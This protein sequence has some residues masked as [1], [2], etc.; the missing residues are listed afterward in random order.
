[1]NDEEGGRRRYPNLSYV[2]HHL[3]PT[4]PYPLES[5]RHGLRWC[6][7][8][9]R[10][11][12]TDCR[13]T[14]VW[15]LRGSTHAK[16][17]VFRCRPRLGSDHAPVGRRGREEG[18]RRIDPTFQWQGTDRLDS[19]E[20]QLL[21]GNGKNDRTT[22]NLCT[23]STNVVVDGK[24]YTPH[25]LSSR[26]K[27]FHGDQWVTVE[28]EV[29]GNTIA[30]KINGDTVLSYADP[31]LDETDGIAKKLIASG[32][33]KMLTGGSISLQSESHSCEFRKVELKKLPD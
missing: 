7:P 2:P 6:V 20:V 4:C 5:C 18:R 26:S 14:R 22:A 12:L 13:C 29:R 31:Q 27:T 10:A 17:A 33:P 11:I 15:P 19:H 23:P 3:L 9:G 16:Y 25:G 28:V 30:H 1:M 24:L 21:G 32:S 8:S